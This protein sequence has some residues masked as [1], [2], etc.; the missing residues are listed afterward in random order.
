MHEGDLPA[1]ARHQASALLFSIAKE[2]S[3]FVNA[4]CVLPDEA[5]ETRNCELFQ[6]LDLVQG[7]RTLATS[8]MRISL[9]TRVVP[10]SSSSS[11]SRKRKH[12]PPPSRKR[13]KKKDDDEEWS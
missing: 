1:Q 10:A 13:K 8:T 5:A 7:R 2:S 12:N 4:R 9:P 11:S 6:N 3:D